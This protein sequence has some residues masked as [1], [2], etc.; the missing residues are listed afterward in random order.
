MKVRAA[1]TKDLPAIAAIAEAAFAVHIPAVG[2]RPAPMDADFDA[3]LAA[4]QLYVIGRP[5]AAYACWF[6][7]G[8]HIHLEALAVAPDQQGKGFGGLLIAAAQAAARAEGLA[9]VELYTNAAMTANLALYQRLG[10][11]VVA[12][13]QINGFDRVY[14]RKDL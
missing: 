2:R 10:F 3:Q 12:R 13:K 5:L 9:A 7:R 1:K 4:G 14:F 8:D 6:A 11:E